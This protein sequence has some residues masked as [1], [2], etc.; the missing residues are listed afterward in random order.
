M[1]RFD[2]I[3][4]GRATVLK[5]RFRESGIFVAITAVLF[6]GGMVFAHGNVNSDIDSVDG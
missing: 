6:P 3:F 2:P 1:Q 5:A 4:P